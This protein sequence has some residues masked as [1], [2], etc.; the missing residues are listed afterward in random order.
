MMHIMFSAGHKVKTD[1]YGSYLKSLYKSKTMSSSSDDQWPP[2]VTDKIFRLAMIKPEEGVRRS[3]DEDG[4]AREKT[5]SGKVDEL[6]KHRVTIELEHV[7]TVIKDQRKSVLIEGAPGSGKSTLSF[8]ICQQWVESKMFQEY[9]LVVLIRLREESI[10]HAKK[11][12]ELLPRRD[13]TMGQDI[14]EEITKNDGRCVLFVFD[15]WDELPQNAPAYSLI[16]N[17]IKGLQLHESSVFITSRPTSS[18]I[19]HPLL[20]LRI[21]ILGFTKD[22]LRLYFKTCL[23]NSHRMVETLLQRIKQNPILEGSCYLPLNASILVHLFKCGGNV[24]PVTQYGI[25]T[26]LVCSCIYRHLK[27]TQQD[28]DELKSLDEL[29]PKVDV[30]FQGLCQIAYNGIMEDKVVFSL[31]SDFNTLGLLQGVESIA[32]RGKSYSFN[33]LHLSIQE[34]LAA[35][36]IATKL[37]DK[38]QTEQFKKLFG[39]PRFSA[40]FQFFAAKTKLQTTGINEIVKQV[41]T[42]HDSQ[43][44]ISLINC[45]YEAQDPSLCQLVVDELHQSHRLNLSETNINPADCYCLGYFLTYCKGFH[46]RI[47]TTGLID[48]H[49]TA[50]FREGQVYDLEDLK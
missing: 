21:E 49:C 32:I 1:E 42:S 17:I 8:H 39:Q 38:E 33:F 24:L 11:I 6:L 44:L 23:Q 20:A 5:I 15:G 50:I 14:E 37:E 25:F 22:E 31:S 19:L 48:D 35:I 28:V 18:A 43:L 40:V 4:L 27:K 10:Q 29:P 3:Y 12:A 36:Y 41:A 13:E 26:E 7:Y 30:L 45:L 47:S 2:P 34:L 16:L 9:K 46:L